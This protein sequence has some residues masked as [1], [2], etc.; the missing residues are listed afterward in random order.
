MLHGNAGCV[1]KSQET[2]SVFF[3][4]LLRVHLKSS[5]ENKSPEILRLKTLTNY[6]NSNGHKY[7][8]G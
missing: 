2:L 8:F 7:P 3:F 1:A 4:T 6:E 5:S